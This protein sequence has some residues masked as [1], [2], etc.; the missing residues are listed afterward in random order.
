MLV[1]CRID[2]GAVVSNES[3]NADRSEHIKFLVSHA[4]KSGLYPAGDKELLE[5]FKKWSNMNFFYIKGE[6]I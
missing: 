3:E 4:M 1:T 6:A 2:S 5:N